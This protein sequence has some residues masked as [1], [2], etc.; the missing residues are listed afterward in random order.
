MLNGIPS[1]ERTDCSQWYLSVPTGVFPVRENGAFRFLL[2][3]VRIAEKKLLMTVLC[4]RFP[5]YSARKV[6]TLGMHM[7][8]NISFLKA[9]SALIAASQTASI[10]K[11]TLWTYGLI[12]VHLMPLYAEKDRI[13]NGLPMYILRVRTS[14]EAGSSHRFLLLLRQVTVLLI[15]RLLLMAGQLTARAERCL[16]RSATVSLRR[17]LSVSTAQIF[18]AFGLQVQTITQIFVSVPRF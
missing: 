7:M 10:R 17:K 11:A 1:G 9:L 6:Q 15:S 18:F 16:N 4:R 3:I 8:R 5:I 14:T 12:P 2:Y 13:L